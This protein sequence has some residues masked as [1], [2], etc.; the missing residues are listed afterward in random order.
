MPES[1]I[2]CH[3]GE[4]EAIVDANDPQFCPMCGRRAE[5]IKLESELDFDD[6]ED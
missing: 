6:D 3:E 5:I 1:R 4:D 2:E